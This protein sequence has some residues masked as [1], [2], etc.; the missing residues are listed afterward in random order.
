M[1][2]IV[3]TEEWIE[4]RKAL[5]EEEKARKQAKSRR[6][7]RKERASAEKALMEK[8]CSTAQESRLSASTHAKTDKSVDSEEDARLIF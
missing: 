5:P 8:E 3:S 6:R 1:A 2:T 7:S 4:A